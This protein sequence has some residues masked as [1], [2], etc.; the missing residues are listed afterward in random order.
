M[1]VWGVWLDGCLWFSCSVRSRKARNLAER[2]DCVVTTDDAR[3]P[4]VLEGRAE[5][6]T[7]EETI[8]A[9]LAAVN[10]K[11]RTDYR[12]DFLDP[13]VNAT[14]RVRPTQAIGLLHTDFPGSPTRWR[15]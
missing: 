12:I 8:A 6:V 7:E 15:W 13:A 14:I 9:F 3:D 10:A 11:Y 4:V 1:P 5:T 2:P